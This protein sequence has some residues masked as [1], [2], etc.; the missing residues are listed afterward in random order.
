MTNHMDILTTAVQTLQ[1]RGGQYGPVEICFDRASKLASVRLN[2]EITMYDIAIIMSCVK[3]ARQ[4]ESPT[5]VDS[6]VDDVNYI[7]I[8]AQFATAQFGGSDTEDGI[9]A[10]AKR[11]A[12]KRQENSNEKNDSRTDG[13]I[14]ADVLKSGW[15]FG[16]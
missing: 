8:A 13:N 5:L 3:Q 6:W 9:T 10:L 12:P 16:S 14:S 7:A 4:V 1:E 11:F 15:P 2:R